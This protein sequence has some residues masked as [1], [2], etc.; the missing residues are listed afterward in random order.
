MDNHIVNIA[1]LNYDKLLYSALLDRNVFQGYNGS[2][3][4][5]FHS[6]GFKP[7]NLERRN[8]HEFG[9]YLHL[10]GSP[11]YYSNENG[12]FKSHITDPLQN[13]P[14]HQRNHFVLTHSTL[15]PEIIT[16]SM[17]LSA[18]WD[19]FNIALNESNTLILFGYGGEDRHINQAVMNWWHP[20]MDNKKFIIISH[21]SDSFKTW[22]KRFNFIQ[23]SNLLL[24]PNIL[25][26]NFIVEQ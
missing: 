25:E 14:Q 16:K 8:E 7:K 3:V 18:Y 19:F 20:K 1:T 10:H 12:I 2:L 6:T 11:L 21:N 22:E 17:L 23:E 5:G 26:Y 15:K 4:D 24:L 9:W 13:T